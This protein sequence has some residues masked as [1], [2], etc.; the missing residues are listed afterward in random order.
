LASL[1]L[2][3]RTELLAYPPAVGVLGS[4]KNCLVCHV[5]NGPWKDDS[6]LII[7]LIDKSTGQS[8]KQPD[9]SFL[10]TAARG[11][12]KTILTVIGARQNATAPSPYRNAWLYLDPERLADTYALSKFAPGWQVNL[13]MSCRLVGDKLEA[14]PGAQL[15]VLPM[16]LRAGDDARDASL[17]LQ[18]MLTKGESVKGKAKE[19]MLGNYFRRTIRL[20]VLPPTPAPASGDAQAKP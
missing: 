10:L 17:E 20:K 1:L 5:E 18:V 4:S 2:S 15:T 13:P 3:P 14:F 12:A 6:N 11:E 19:G 16:T 8:L 9:G 7:E